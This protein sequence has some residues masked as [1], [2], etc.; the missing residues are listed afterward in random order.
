MKVFLLHRDQ[1]FDVK[2][3]TAR[4]DLRRDAERQ[5][6]RDRQRQARPRTRER[7]REPTR[8]P[9]E[10][11]RADA[12]P[13]ARHALERDGGRRRVPVR[14]GQAR[15]P[16][17]PAAIPRRSCIASGVLADCLDASRDRPAALRPRDRGAR[18]RTEGRR[19]LWHSDRP[20][21][22]LHRSVQVLDAARGRP[23][24][25]PADRRRAGRELSTRRDSRASSRCSAR[26]SPTT[27][28]QTV[29]QHLRELEFKRG[30]LESAE[31]GK[32]NKGRRYVVR[33][34][35][36]QR[37]TER[38]AVRQPLT[39]LQLHD[40]APRRERLQGAGR[41]PRAR[42]QPGRQRGR[43]VRRSRQELLQHAPARARLLPRLPQPARA[44]RR[45]GRADLLPR[46]R[47]PPTQPTLS[48]GGLYDVCLTLHLED[49]AVGND[50]DADGKSLVMITGANQGGKS[51]LLRSLGLAHLMMQCGMF[52]GARSFRANVCDR[53][54]H[55]LQARRG[56]DHGERQARR[57]AGAG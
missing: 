1:D 14:D 5:P 9:P 12:G 29:E 24:A 34:P 19:R 38:L 56:R 42:D 39:E 50:V 36:A 54:L 53:R 8:A 30:V 41:D 16:V 17:E 13:R 6:V 25:T 32:G 21:T 18:E 7:Q 46:R 23:Q 51:T 43:A 55:A 35:R 27:T 52:V 33:R 22:I 26:S 20:D 49:R 47:W 48:A 57:G 28:S 45:E 15:R 2:P 10:R 3:A 44:A 11:R 4:R 40:P 37:W 31:L